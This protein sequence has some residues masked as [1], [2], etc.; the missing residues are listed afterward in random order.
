MMRDGRTIPAV[1]ALAV[2]MASCAGNPQRLPV[3]VSVC[4]TVAR[5]N[6]FGIVANVE[7]KSDR[8]ISSLYLSTA[9]YQNF[10]YQRYTGSARLSSELDP[11]QKRDVTFAVEQSSGA[12]PQG[13]AIR[14][15][16]THIGYLDGT[17]QDAPP[18]L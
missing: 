16:I 17:S 13:Q 6:G 4:S 12:K 2:A 5:T 8:P 7:N 10:R 18:S 14:C 1:A 9:F 15:F 3:G 11:G